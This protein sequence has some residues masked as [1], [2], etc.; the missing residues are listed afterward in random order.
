[1]QNMSWWRAGVEPVAEPAHGAVRPLGRVAI[2]ALV[3]LLAACGFRLAGSDPLPP[4]LA[5]P[6]LSLK[7]PYTDF[8]REFEHQ[9]KSSGALVQPVRAGAT[10][11]IEVTR[12]FVEQR[13]LS[14]SANN[15]PTE[16]ELI[17]TVTFA[18]HG[19]DKE[20]LS[21]QTISLSKDYSFEE[22]LLLAKEHEADILR[23]QMA[24]DLVAIA[25][26]RLTSLK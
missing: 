23:Q 6:Y 24:R 16:Y 8:S 7:D 12:D 10:A 25:M 11:S 20:L 22:N 13:T 14:V 15:I 18:V 1:M 21:P 5:R 9:L 17:Y 19:A 26:R 2:V 3:A 4:V